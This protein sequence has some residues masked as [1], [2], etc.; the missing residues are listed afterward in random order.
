MEKP[1]REIV[2]CDEINE[3]ST[4]KIIEEIIKI[5]KYDN[6][7][8]NLLSKYEREPIKFYMTTNGGNAYLT[9]ALFDHIKYSKTPVWIY[10]SG[11]CCSGGFYMLGAAKK[12]IAYNHTQLMYHQL[13]YGT[14]YNYL[15]NHKQAVKESENLQKVLDLLILE[16]TNIT[17]EMLKIINDKQID[18]YM[19]T[20][21]A[22]DLGVIDEII[23]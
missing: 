1:T 18:W 5:N 3:E 19:S 9:I 14:R 6:E 20:K 17:S 10:I 21:E 15:E 8:E 16:N 13:S 11:Y 12:V 4:K 2:F 23:L 22:L 7:Q